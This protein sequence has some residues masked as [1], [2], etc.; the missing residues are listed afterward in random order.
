[1]NKSKVV[2]VAVLIFA[3]FSFTGMGYAASAAGDKRHLEWD[4]GVT[5]FPAG[6][7]EDPVNDKGYNSNSKTHIKENSKQSDW[8]I[9]ITHFP[10]GDHKGPVN[11]QG[12]SAKHKTP[13]T[14]DV[15]HSDW[16][17]G[18]TRF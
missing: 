12:F 9:G 17:V 2:S 15:R 3:L 14:E 4:I 5:H 10:S 7:K 16:D 11:D 1:M 13:V 6:E 8:D 18:I